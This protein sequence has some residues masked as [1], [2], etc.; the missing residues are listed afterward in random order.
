MK[1]SSQNLPHRI[2]EFLKRSRPQSS[3]ALEAAP[4]AG[5]WEG[6]MTHR[7]ITMIEVIGDPASVAGR[8]SDPAYLSAWIARP[9]VAM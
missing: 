1:D 9:S 4:L 2:A 5:R 8:G 3:V 7:E 6:A